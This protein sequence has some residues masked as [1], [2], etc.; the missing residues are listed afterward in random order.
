MFFR[1]TGLILSGPAALFGFN[2]FNNFRTP[3]SVIFIE[4][5][6]GIFFFKA[7]LHKFLNESGDTSEKNDL[8]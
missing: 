4:S 8:N 3:F 1:T 6:V 7:C 5:I 2:F